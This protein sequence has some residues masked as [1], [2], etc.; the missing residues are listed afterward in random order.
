MAGPSRRQPLAS[1][2][3]QKANEKCNPPAE[4]PPIGEN[5]EWQV[6]VSLLSGWGRHQLSMARKGSKSREVPIPR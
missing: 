5:P 2:R 1:G 4:G 3:T 6:A